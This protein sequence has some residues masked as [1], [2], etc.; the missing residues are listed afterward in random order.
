VSGKFL[1]VVAVVLGAIVVLLLNSMISDYEKKANPPTRTFYRA[2]ADIAPGITVADAI[3]DARRLIV[4]EKNIPEGF[5]KAYPYAVDDIQMEYTKKRRISR[6]IKAGEFLMQEHLDPLSAEDIRLSIP[7][8][9]EAVSIGV[10]A[11]SSLGYLVA[12]GD[13]VDV[14]LVTTKTD[15]KTPGASTIEAKPI[16]TDAPVWAIDS[17]VGRKDGVPVRPRGTTY[18]TVTVTATHEDAMKILA[19]KQQGKLTLVLKSKKPG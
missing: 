17:L 2:T 16:V 13:V 1:V 3:A 9:Q 5:A 4:A 6:P 8:G 15:P 12:P 7:D 18:T 11:E 10:N 19:A 14:V